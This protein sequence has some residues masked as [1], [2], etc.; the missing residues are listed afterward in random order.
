MRIINI[1]DAPRVLN[2]DAMARGTGAKYLECSAH[3][4]TS[5]REQ[6]IAYKWRRKLPAGI[7]PHHVM[8]AFNA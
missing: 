6:L 7:P 4:D 3:F 2:L 5:T 8:I 1:K